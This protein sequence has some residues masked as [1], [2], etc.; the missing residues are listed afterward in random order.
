[1]LTATISTITESDQLA[2]ALKGSKAR[3]QPYPWRGHW[4]NVLSVTQKGG[5]EIT[6]NLNGEVLPMR[7]APYWEV[8]LER[9]S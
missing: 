4:Y 3:N 1:M 7:C 5:P 2:E 8:E 6:M 9:L